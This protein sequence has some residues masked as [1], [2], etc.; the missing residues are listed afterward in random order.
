MN[1]VY[2]LKYSA[3]AR[4][5]IAVSELTRKCICKGI[6]KK[7]LI[8]LML[9]SLLGFS[10]GSSGSIVSAEIDYQIFRDFAENK[11]IFKPG[12][13]NLAIYY[14]SGEL[15]GYL[16][17]APM[18]DFSSVNVRNAAGVAT[19][20]S[21][22]YI[23]SVK[24]N[25]GYKS[26]QFGNTYSN[27]DNNHFQYVLVDRNNH[28]SVDFHLPRLSKLVTEAEPS[29]INNATQAETMDISRFPVFYRLGSGT[30]YTQD[31]DG[32]RTYISGAYNYLTGGTVPV[33]FITH[34]GSTGIQIYMGGNINNHGLMAS[35]GQAGDSGSPLFGWDS[36]KNK[37]VLVAV[38]S[39]I[40]G[41]TNPIWKLVP[42]TFVDQIM[43][44]NNDPDVIFDTVSGGSL[45]WTF[46]E[47]SGTGALV[48][49]EQQFDMHGQNGT[50][51]NAGKNLTFYGK[52]GVIDLENDVAQGAGSLTFKDN[53]TV[54]SSTGSIWTGA[55]ITVE[56]DATVTWQ[57]NG[58]S[59]DALHKI[60][61]GTLYVNASGNNEGALRVGDGT[62]ILDQQPDADGN[63][64]AFS[65]V[66]ITSGRPTVV[67]SDSFQVNPDNI[68]FGYR[69]GRLDVNGNDLTFSRIRNADSGAH[70]VNN[71]SSQS[72]TLSVI[73]RGI[74][75][76]NDYQTFQGFFGETD[77]E[78][79]NGELNLNYSPEAGTGILNLS[80]GA[81]LN[82]N[83]SVSNG[84]MLLLSGNPV[85]HAG[86][87]FIEGDWNS[88]QFTLDAINVGSDSSL[89]VSEYTTLNGD[90]YAE[91]GASVTF[92]YVDGETQRCMLNQDTGVTSCSNMIKDN[93]PEADKATVNV[94]SDVTL[95]KNAIMSIGNA[96]FNGTVTGNSGSALIMTDKAVWNVKNNSSLDSF[97]ARGGLISFIDED[98]SW[99]P[100]ALTVDTMNARSLQIKLG[101]SASEN[102]SDKL[103]ILGQATGGHNTLDLSSVFDQMVLLTEDITLASAPSGTSH[104]Y[105]SFTSLNRGFTVYTPDTQV[106]EQEGKV[107]WQ[108]KHNSVLD[109]EI[110]EMPE[111]NKSPGTDGNANG[112]AENEVTEGS[113]T[114]GS[115]NVSESTDVLVKGETLF[116]GEDNVAL[117][118]KARNMFTSRQFI[119]NDNIDR[120]QQV[121]DSSGSDSGFWAMTG[122][123]HGGYDDFTLNQS[124]LD[125]G[126]KKVTDSGY[127]G[128]TAEF[129]KGYSRATS[130]RDDYNLWG[131]N[132][133]VGKSFSFGAFVDGSIGYK[134]LTEDFSIQGELNDL[135][136]RTESHIAMLGGR[137]GYRWHSELLDMTFTPSVSID[138]ANLNG[139]KIRG[140]EQRYAELHSGSAVWLKTG[141]LAEKS[142]ESAKMTAGL[143]RNF[144]LNDMPG[145]RLGDAWKVREYGAENDERYTA[146]VGVEGKI[147]ENLRVQLKLNNSF[148]GYFKTDSEGVLGLNYVF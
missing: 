42:T 65:S 110:A 69:G 116:K 55:G 125:V 119:V 26:V 50:D 27:P 93:V 49:G 12:A 141:V 60:G 118:K 10:G 136:G 146:T 70:I 61:A 40:G 74:N 111:N 28:S 121:I 66:T 104:G 106:V 7:N 123:S 83:I 13:Q 9:L 47:A 86:N 97:S 54:S 129:Y 92:G 72:A 98:N 16:D 68:Y 94:N 25:G 115:S 30:Q 39:A 137:V 56:K 112:T 75:N 133:F 100:K 62:V 41:G 51:L 15:A 35:F 48:Q 144:T 14:K 124:G 142:F 37:W 17:K 134:R 43:S 73:G 139:N 122:Y 78:R 19:L 140:K 38:Y 21:P 57:I 147:T 24:H 80:G 96:V 102:T 113:S 1:K 46:D 67:L 89:Q 71:S 44:E 18:P 45:V 135:S 59:G 31:I 84:G 3:A 103:E 22:Q 90:I 20:V 79:H 77:G 2:S 5:Y 81:N 109:A 8:V 4:G 33:P 127:W 101:V 95:Q 148:D 29:E 126:F 132:I 114:E 11:G 34:G 23:A 76:Q 58:E 143:Y 82:G 128:A 63:K 36:E 88:T 52:N 105:F 131:V 117:L 145:M 6:G 32:N 85:L 87:V 64:Q 138:A 99:S 130:Y 120:W 53:Y 108:L 107:L 91:N